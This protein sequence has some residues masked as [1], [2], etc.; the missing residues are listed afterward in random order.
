M[1]N[2]KQDKQ[3]SQTKISWFYYKK[4]RQNQRKC[5][6]PMC[7]EVFSSVNIPGRGLCVLCCVYMLPSE[8]GSRKDARHTMSLLGNSYSSPLIIL[9]SGRCWDISKREPLRLISRKLVITQINDYA[10]LATQ[11]TKKLKIAHVCVL[12]G[13]NILEA[14][15]LL[16]NYETREH[17]KLAKW[18]RKQFSP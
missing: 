7:H 13:D 11:R 17:W 18:W 1:E 6:A 2:L 8:A 9:S 14:L 12:I 5:L 3:V 16:K 10:G 4:H 15:Q